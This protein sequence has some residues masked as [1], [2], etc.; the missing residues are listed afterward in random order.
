VN[1][2]LRN[3]ALITEKDSGEI[4]ARIATPYITDRCFWLVLQNRPNVKGGKR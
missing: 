3:L 4:L 1:A 2:Q